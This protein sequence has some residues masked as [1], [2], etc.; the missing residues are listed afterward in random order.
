M[1]QLIRNAIVLILFFASVNIWATDYKFIGSTSGGYGVGNDPTNWV[2]T[3]GTPTN[4]PDFYNQTSID[5]YDFNGKDVDLNGMTVGWIRFFNSGA[6]C[7]VVNSGN[8]DIYL[9]FGGVVNFDPVYNLTTTVNYDFSTSG[10]FNFYTS[11]TLSPE[12]YYNLVITECTLTTTATSSVSNDLKFD[13]GNASQAPTLV[14]PNFSTF[15]LSNSSTTITIDNA[16]TLQSHTINVQGTLNDSRTSRSYSGNFIHN[17]S[18]TLTG[19]SY[20]DLNTKFSTTLIGNTTIENN[21]TLS[22]AKSV[23][24]ISTYKLTVG[25]IINTSVSAPPAAAGNS[26]INVSQGTLV[27]TKSQYISKYNLGTNTSLTGLTN[28]TIY[29]LEP[30]ANVTI[31]ISS[32]D[33]QITNNLN[34]TNA[35][36]K[37]R[38]NNKTLIL[39]GSLTSNSSGGNFV[40]SPSSNLIC[41]TAYN[42]TVYFDQT[43]IDSFTLNNLNIGNNT[44]DFT[45]G[46]NLCL[47]TINLANGRFYVNGK[48]LTFIGTSAQPITKTSGFIDASDNSTTPTYPSIIKYAQTDTAN[49]IL[50]VSAYSGN[51]DNLTLDFSNASHA[52]LTPSSS[53]TI[54]KKLTMTRSNNYFKI[55]NGHTLTLLGEL[56]N[57]SSGLE[58]GKFTGNPTANIEYLGTNDAILYFDQRHQNARTLK[59]LKIG[60]SSITV[61]LGNWLEITG[62]DGSPGTFGIVDVVAASNKLYTNGFLTLKSNEYGTGMIGNNPGTIAY[63][64]SSNNGTLLV[65]NYIPYINRGRQYRFLSSPVS[66]GNFLQWRDSLNTRI[67]RGIHIT[68]DYTKTKETTGTPTPIDSFDMS[69]TN[70][71]TAFEYDETKAGNTTGFGSTSGATEDAG[72]VRFNQANTKSIVNGKGY[73]ILVRGDRTRWIV[74]GGSSTD[75]DANNTTI[76]TRGGYVAGPVSVAITNSG[77]KTNNGI[78]L[79]G[80]P[81]ACAVNWNTV[82]AASSNVDPSYVLYDPVNKNWQAYNANSSTPANYQYISPG[83]GF[84]VYTGNSGGGSV[85]FS[86]SSKTTT[87]AGSRTFTEIKTNHLITHLRKDTTAADMNIIYFLNGATNYYDKY[88]AGHIQ[89]DYVNLSSLDSSNILYNINCLDSL[90][91]QRI[92]PMSVYGTPQGKYTMTFDDV[93]TFR[94]HDVYLIDNFLQKTTKVDDMTQYNVDITEDKFSYAEGRFF[95]SFEPKAASSIVTINK[96]DNFTISPNPVKDQINVNMKKPVSGN[97]HYEIFNINGQLISTGSLNEGESKI[98]SNTMNK[99]IYF[100]TLKTNTETQTIKFIK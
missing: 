3:T 47:N 96:T 13:Y 42:R 88:D 10:T 16:G 51:I 76:Q 30:A 64:S 22:N 58:G 36:S 20:Y 80:N 12:D 39:D 70:F 72:W 59:N 37:I 29:N 82:Y 25:K 71:P 18:A 26:R 41:T 91:S 8:V 83:Q 79:I 68:G 94:N 87:V 77:S 65:E 60:G 75:Y 52:T 61:N 23:L 89:N 54:S 2:T 55:G 19:T 97:L 66:G 50:D 6:S 69:T 35:N 62:G 15:N 14:I 33:L 78:N 98:N 74:S 7:K 81:Y 99:G 90:T 1:N 40:G 92:V 32:S 4:P 11:T 95:I 57:T 73:R 5:N 38:L 46:S 86:T 34:L 49:H 67:G 85:E 84:L 24:N 100:L 43:S 63:S 93:N 17:T 48:T 27:L 21:L 28:A 45:L 56:V 9:P 53:I 31:A 44:V